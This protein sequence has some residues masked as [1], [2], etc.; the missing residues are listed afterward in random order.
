MV[1]LRRT[2]AASPGSPEQRS[3]L[4]CS[5]DPFDSGSSV[6]LCIASARLQE[7]LCIAPAD[8][9][10]ADIFTLSARRVRSGCLEVDEG[11][12]LVEAF[13]NQPARGFLVDPIFV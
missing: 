3:S 10:A 2:D 4:S 5:P 6:T 12:V 1:Q 13:R 9:G 8:S 11:H 7:H